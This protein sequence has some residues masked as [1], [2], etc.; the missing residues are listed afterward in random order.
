VDEQARQLS[1][2]SC[3]VSLVLPNPNGKHYLLNLIDCPGHVNFS[4]ECSAGM[5]GADG[6]VL[7]RWL[8]GYAGWLLCVYMVCAAETGMDTSWRLKLQKKKAFP[9]RL[10]FFFF[11][12]RSVILTP[13]SFSSLVHILFLRKGN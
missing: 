3:P 12:F 13:F 2:K 8:V 4:D 6:V 10:L 7:V 9:Q 11:A 1:V 5:R